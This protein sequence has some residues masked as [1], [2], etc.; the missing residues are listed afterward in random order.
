VAPSTKKIPAKCKTAAV[1]TA[2]TLEAIKSELETLKVALGD[3]PQEFV[4]QGRLSESV[5][6]KNGYPCVSTRLSILS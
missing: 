3:L 2:T 5:A 4:V 1:E 6:S